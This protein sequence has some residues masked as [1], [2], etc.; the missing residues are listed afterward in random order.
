MN[1]AAIHV[2]I[3]DDHPIFRLGLA[4][5][6]TSRGFVSVRVS[7]GSVSDAADL[8]PSGATGPWVALL[9][10]RLGAIDG[11]RICRNLRAAPNPP[12]VVMLST[13]EEPAVVQSA[14]DAGAFA[15]L[16][17]E[18]DVDEIVATIEEGL[19]GARSRIPDQGMPL[20]TP[21]ERDVLALLHE[22][23]DNKRIAQR[24]G[25]GPATVKDHLDH[26][27]GKLGVSDRLG[28]VRAATALGLVDP[29]S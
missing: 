16:S 9:D 8:A 20:L 7:D 1:P 27:Y 11:I 13:F 25:I 24:L 5:V 17:K 15:F 28:A 19:R 3:V 18:A 12:L 26:I 21:R 10:V 6:L 29:L 22:G 2:L 14:K 4:S 23:L